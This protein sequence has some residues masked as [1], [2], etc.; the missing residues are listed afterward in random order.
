MIIEPKYVPV[1]YDCKSPNIHCHA[2][3]VWSIEQQTWILSSVSK[4]FYCQECEDECDA[5]KVI[6]P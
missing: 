2:H 1:C 5:T 6:V 4:D 3:A